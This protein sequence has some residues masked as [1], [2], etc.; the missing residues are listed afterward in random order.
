MFITNFSQGATD[1]L[2]M[3]GIFTAIG[4]LGVVIS[5]F[6]PETHK[7]DFPETVEDMERR[8]YHPYF[9]FRVWKKK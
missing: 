8:E 5:S 7:Q 6:I 4:A 9:S 1:K 3:Y 2:M